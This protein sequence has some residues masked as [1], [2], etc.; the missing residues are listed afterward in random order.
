MRD[1]DDACVNECA[2]L[3]E[4]YRHIIIWLD[5]SLVTLSH[6]RT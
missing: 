1:R 2:S 6:Q 4:L 5:H 3:K